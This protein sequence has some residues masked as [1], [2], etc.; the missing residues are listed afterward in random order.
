MVQSDVIL[1]WRGASDVVHHFEFRSHVVYRRSRYQL[2]PFLL[3]C[4]VSFR[5]KWSAALLCERLLMCTTSDVGA[6]TAIRASKL[7]G[8]RIER[9]PY[10]LKT[11]QG[12]FLREHSK[13][14]NNLVAVAIICD[15]INMTAVQT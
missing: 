1:R 8:H 5:R 6:Y 11:Q 3:R 12:D 15:S 10:L 9:Y 4:D 13:A 2:P 14:E 7:K